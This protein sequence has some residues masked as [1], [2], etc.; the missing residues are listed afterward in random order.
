MALWKLNGEV[1]YSDGPLSVSTSEVPYGYV[2][3]HFYIVPY[4]NVGKGAFTMQDGKKY[5]VPSWTEVHPETTFEDIIV[6]KK[7]FQE[8][9]VEPKTWSF[10]SASSD[11]VYTVRLT[12]NN[13]LSCDC[14]GYIAHKKCKHIKQVQEELV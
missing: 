4:T 2:V 5:H 9:F 13:K 6:E 12:K 8:L 7:P 3:R 10:E 14:W 11:K 1:V